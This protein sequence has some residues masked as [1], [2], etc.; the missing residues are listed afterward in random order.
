MT[1]SILTR[2][3]SIRYFSLAL[4]T[5][6]FSWQIYLSPQSRNCKVSGVHIDKRFI[7]S[8]FPIVKL[9]HRELNSVVNGSCQSICI[10]LDTLFKSCIISCIIMLL[11]ASLI[12]MIIPQ[13]SREMLSEMV[14]ERKSFKET[15]F[16]SAC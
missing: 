4:M 5:L 12:V 14:L 7:F 16:P 15:D 10:W 8:Q 9:C 2:H 1:S 6:K 13:R 3:A 11:V